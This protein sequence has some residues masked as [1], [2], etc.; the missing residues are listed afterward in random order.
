MKTKITVKV[1][2]KTVSK[3]SKNK[4][5]VKKIQRALKQNGYYLRYAGHYLM[6]DGA[7][8]DCTVRSVKEF[9][10][11]NNL[12]VTGKV[13]YNTAKKLKLVK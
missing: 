7:Y 2:W 9:Q 5:M 4:A 13:D 1:T 12:K 6:I 3:G 8:N 10:K 11:D